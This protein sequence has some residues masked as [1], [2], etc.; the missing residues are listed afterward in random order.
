MCAMKKQTSYESKQEE[1][2]LPE[3]ERKKRKKSA[4]YSAIPSIILLWSSF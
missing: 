2:Y 3:I 4:D 1:S